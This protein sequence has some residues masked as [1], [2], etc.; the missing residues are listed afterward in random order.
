MLM[1]LSLNTMVDRILD[2]LNVDTVTLSDYANP[3]SPVDLAPYVLIPRFREMRPLPDGGNETINSVA[4]DYMVFL[5]RPD[6]L[7]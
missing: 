1:L 4:L 2:E 7:P 5:Y 6:V 3:Q